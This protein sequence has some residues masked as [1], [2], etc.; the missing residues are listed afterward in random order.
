MSLYFAYGSNLDADQMRA[1]CPGFARRSARAERSVLDDDERAHGVTTY[2]V[3]EKGR[4][5]PTREYPDEILRWGAHWRFPDAYLERL[6]ATT[7]A[8]PHPR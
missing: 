8:P 2:V 1:R 5:P 3:V 7:P 6:R 4:F